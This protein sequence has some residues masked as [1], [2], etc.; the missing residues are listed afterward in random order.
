MVI[1]TDVQVAFM[2]GAFFADIGARAI[3]AARKTSAEQL[4]VVYCQ[5]RL[6]ALAYASVFVG[7][8]ATTFML[9][10]PAWES[11]YWSARF[12]ATAGSFGNSVYFGI[13]LLLLFIG[14][15]FGNWLGFRWV[16][17][18]ARKRLRI[19]YISVLLI[20]LVVVVVQWPAPIRLGSY[21]EFERDPAS[22][23]Y[24]WQDRGF[25]VSFWAITGYCTV[26]L[27]VWFVQIRRRER[28]TS[29]SS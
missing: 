16:L 14:A 8:A 15:W 11:Q 7:P 19:V 28:K 23:P 17:S 25:F 29:N 20:T 2:V 12:D 27:V 21:A 26:P 3:E 5:Y 22:L 10:W 24:I 13:F 18:A 9:G 1:P 4:K 6:R